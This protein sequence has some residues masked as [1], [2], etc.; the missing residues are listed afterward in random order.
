MGIR[1]PTDGKAIWGLIP[2]VLAKVSQVTFEEVQFL[3]SVFGF[4]M[5][6]DLQR[7]SYLFCS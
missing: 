2:F 5:K 1:A 6:R 4:L 7:W 3:A